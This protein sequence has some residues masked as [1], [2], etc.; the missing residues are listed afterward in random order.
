MACCRRLCA[1]L[2][3]GV[4][5]Q[6]GKGALGFLFLYELLTGTLKFGVRSEDSPYLLASYLVALLPEDAR[7]GGVKAPPGSLAGKL[8]AILD[9]ACAAPSLVS[10]MPKFDDTRKFKLTTIVAGQD[11]AKKLLRNVQQYFSSKRAD[12][13]RLPRYRAHP[14][15]AVLPV[16]ALDA[17]IANGARSWR[18][19]GY[20]ADTAM[21]QRAVHRATDVDPARLRLEAG[22][23][24]H[25]AALL[26]A[27][28]CDADVIACG[29][30]PLASVLPLTT[31]LITRIPSSSTEVSGRLPFEVG[32]NVAAQSVV[33]RR[34]LARLEVDAAEYAAAERERTTPMIR[35]LA[36][37]SEIADAATAPQPHLERVAELTRRLLVLRAADAAYTQKAAELSIL[38][39]GEGGGGVRDKAWALKIRGGLEAG[40]WFESLVEQL[41]DTHGDGEL[42]DANPSLGAR[43]VAVVRELSVRALLAASRAAQL[44]RCCAAAESLCAALVSAVPDVAEITLRSRAFAEE[45][46]SRRPYCRFDGVGDGALFHFDPRLLVFEFVHGLLLRPAQCR[47]VETFV[48]SACKGVS[49][50]EQMIMGGGKTTV[51]SPLLA[52]FLGDGARLVCQVVPHALLEFSRNTMR[53]RF[54]IIVKKPVYTL[55][56]DRYT[57]LNLT[58]SQKLECA[59]LQRAVLCASPTAIKSFMLKLLELLDE[60]DHAYSLRSTTSTATATGIFSFWRRRGA[61]GSEID[62]VVLRSQAEIGAQVLQLFNGSHCLLDEVD[63]ILH[64][65][66]SELN[67]PLGSKAPLDFTVSPATGALGKRWL[68]PYHLLDAIFFCAGHD[69]SVGDFSESIEAHNHLQ[70]VK[71]ALGDGIKDKVVQLAP[72]VV[73]LSRRFY[74]SKMLRPLAGWALLYLRTAGLRGIE[75]AVALDYLTQGGATCGAANRAT[76][77]TNVDDEGVKLLNLMSEWLR[78][79]LPFVLGK[80]NRVSFGLLADCDLERLNDARTPVSRRLCAVPFVGKDVPSRA[81]E[82]SQPDVVIGLTILAY[83]YEGL[84]VTDFAIVLRLLR[85]TMAAETGP[86]EKRPA[87]KNFARWVRVAGGRVRGPGGL[88][89]GEPRV[90]KVKAG[91]SEVQL[92]DLLFEYDDGLCSGMKYDDIWPLHIVNVH[93]KE[94]LHALFCLLR[95]VPLVSRHYLHTHVFP[96][97][98]AHQGLKLSA[99]GQDLGGDLIF[100]TRLG[101]SGTPSEL[102]PLEL[103]AC[104]YER[105]SD[106]K[107]VAILSDSSVCASAP[108]PNDWNADSVLS[109]CAQGDL[110]ALIDTGALVTGYGNRDVAEALLFGKGKFGSLPTLPA[111]KFDGVVYLDDADRK[112]ILVRDGCRTLPLDQSGIPAKRRFCFYDQIHTTGMDIKQ[113]LDSRAAITLA[114]DMTVSHRVESPKSHPSC[115]LLF[116]YHYV[117]LTVFHHSFGIMLKAPFECV[118]LGKARRCWFS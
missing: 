40:L 74:D 3:H 65:L 101:F 8:R 81:S 58:F 48:S 70:T 44:G 71:R 20:L 26:C 38:A 14:A 82:F 67:W 37:L 6:G 84:R 83:R 23:K 36:T 100:G 66:R 22:T 24:V 107:M 53:E 76:V 116:G 51:V 30:R 21:P 99:C 18:S 77:N 39:A 73:V 106:G 103:G 60:L 19:V 25:T 11:V 15:Q 9:V 87:C 96:A 17:V 52:L 34:T 112:M 45:L 56:F 2:D 111:E 92:F 12:L 95:K 118:V 98:C 28:F 85:E 50:C 110:S 86:Y 10:G 113:G 102:L 68:A 108:L 33:A 104:C 1:V 55:R 97:T 91:R 117:T 115:F 89:G 47:L 46:D 42:N 4:E 29:D 32:A 94:Q 43:G 88:G 114:K 62:E 31:E 13:A 57:E 54:S 105:E 75:D 90:P 59:A 7:G 93:D 16:I 69:L 64:P 63:L 61:D 49:H 5:L 78:N 72:H 41:L 80:V 109:R 35:G 79:I 27:K